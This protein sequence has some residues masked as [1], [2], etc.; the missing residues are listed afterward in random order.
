[1]RV[2]SGGWK[3]E[4]LIIGS[5]MVK[6]EIKYKDVADI[7]NPMKIRLFVSGYLKRG[8][9]TVLCRQVPT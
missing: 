2:R 3:E 7:S 9:I 5:L 1:M 6:K 4:I 8:L